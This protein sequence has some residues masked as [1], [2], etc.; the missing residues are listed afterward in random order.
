M[1]RIDGERDLLSVRH[2]TLT[3]VMSSIRLGSLS[4]TRPE[5]SARLVHADFHAALR[6]GSATEKA[7]F[8]GTRTV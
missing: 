5:E 2:T 7:L 3:L 6:T 4:L 8:S 1:N